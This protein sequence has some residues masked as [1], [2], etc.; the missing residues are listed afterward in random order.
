MILLLKEVVETSACISLG[1][2]AV[3]V[4]AWGLFKARDWGELLLFVVYVKC[5]M[6]IKK[7]TGRYAKII[8]K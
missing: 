1:S 7:R 6:N 2:V 3:I 4:V 5:R 8:S